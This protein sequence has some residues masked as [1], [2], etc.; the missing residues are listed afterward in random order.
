MEDSIER[1]EA[2]ASLIKTT[3]EA[4]GDEKAKPFEIIA[5][6]E[7]IEMDASHADELCPYIRVIKQ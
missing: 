7:S 6:Y 5:K 3:I 2:L 1:T 4:L